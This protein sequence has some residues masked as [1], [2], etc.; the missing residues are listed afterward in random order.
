VFQGPDDAPAVEPLVAGLGG[1]PHAVARDTTLGQAAA[2]IER[3]RLM[4]STDSAL[5][6]L[7]AA[8]GTP[9]VTIWGPSDP[10]R[11][12]PWTDRGKVVQRD[13]A[14]GPCLHLWRPIV[15]E[16]DWRCLRELGVDDVFAAAVDLFEETKSQEPAS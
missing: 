5:S 4:V 3:C 14:C 10:A 12:R 16:Y 13:E 15:C 6:H 8:V 7:A 1:I 9:I 11:T 2:L